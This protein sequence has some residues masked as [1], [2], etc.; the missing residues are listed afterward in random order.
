MPNQLDQDIVRLGKSIRKIESNDDFTARGGSGEFGGY[1]YTEPT[2]NAQAKAAGVN[3]PLSAANREQQNQVWYTWAKKKKDEGYNIGQIA[4]MHNAGEGNPDA[5]IKG[6]K[7]TNKYGVSYDTKAYAEKVAAFYQG[8][9]QSEGV[10][11]AP[12][13]GLGGNYPAPHTDATTL[14]DIEANAAQELA[15]R[16]PQKDWAQK[17]LEFLFPIL[18]KKD[19]TA[20]QWVGDA[21]LSALTLLPGAGLAGKGLQAAGLI[22]KGA[23]AAKVAPTLTKTVAQGLGIGY[24]ADVASHLSQGD[25]DVKE[26]L[27]PGLGTAVGG[28]GGAALHGAGKLAPAILSRTSGVPQAALQH[29]ADNAPA[30]KALIKAGANPKS[31][32][33]LGVQAVKQLRKSMSANWESGVTNIAD[34]YAGRAVG[35]PEGIGNE[36]KDIASRYNTATKSRITIPQ[37]PYSMS[38]KELT[39]LIKDIN[40]IKY[41]PLAPDRALLDM[42]TYLKNLGKKNF[43]DG[44]EFTELYSN[45][46]TKSDILDAA[47]D[48]IRAYKTKK[49]TQITTSINRLQSVFNEGKEEYLKAIQ[50]LEQET[51]TDIL[52]HIAASKT[53][54][55]MPID[56]EKGLQLTD[57]LQW[58]GV[59]VTSPRAAAELNRILTGKSTGLVGRTLK[60]AAKLTPV[61]PGLMSR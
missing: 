15:N 18:E 34:K 13:A 31:T 14:K 24:G 49:P 40:G 12:K 5:Y 4:S 26:I 55:R 56:L 32:H 58:A 44:G 19:R 47:D 51:G 60:G 16:G 30:V 57:L 37:N 11:T 36:L 6:N 39:G 21:G 7:G 29:S 45:Y 41:N 46:A 17:G 27:T 50:A 35:L 53:G 59:L 20:M 9:K 25:T 10:N 38:A 42:K 61:V 43:N 2:W 33:E 54:S 3:V 48:I 1:Q 23:K 28:I 8:L 22:A 52:S